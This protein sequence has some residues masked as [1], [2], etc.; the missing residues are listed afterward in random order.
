MSTHTS[1]SDEPV[2]EN[3]DSGRS[4]TWLKD[5]INWL[6]DNIRGADGRRF[7]FTRVAE[8]SGNRVGASTISRLCDGSI[9]N[10][11][12]DTLYAI[13][14]FFGLPRG[15]LVNDPKMNELFGLAEKNDPRGLALIE[16]MRAA[17][18]IH[19][20]RIRALAGRLDRIETLN[21]GIMPDA[22]KAIS[23]MLDALEANISPPR[24][25]GEK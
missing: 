14:D 25:E 23:A 1:P 9:T 16:Q 24:Q 2:P 15:A 11:K 21:P 17:R 6:F 12:V 19:D 4:D 22:I 5:R 8:A 20:R 10:P 18:V 13:A 3:P 7:S